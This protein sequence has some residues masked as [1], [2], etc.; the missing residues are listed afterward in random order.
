MTDHRIRLTLCRLE[1]FMLGDLDGM[2]DAL[3][4]QERAN[5][6]KND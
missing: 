1:A 4:V 3:A 6:L 2:I 5:A